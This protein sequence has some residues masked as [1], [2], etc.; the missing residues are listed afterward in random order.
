MNKKIYFVNSLLWREELN[1]LLLIEIFHYHHFYFGK[2]F[3]CVFEREKR[4]SR[5]KKK[6][7][8]WGCVKVHY[9]LILR[10]FVWLYNFINIS[11]IMKE[12]GEVSSAFSAKS[13][14][15][16]EELWEKIYFL[17][18]SLSLHSTIKPPRSTIKGIALDTIAS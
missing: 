15:H 18:I 6:E 5:R 3:R 11:R 17:S 1:F 7:K 2:T 8:S 10:D 13:F 16:V 12:M 4:L 9:S 14:L